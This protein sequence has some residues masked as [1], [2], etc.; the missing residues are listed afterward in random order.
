ML[1]VTIN[2]K[3]QRL[4]SLNGKRVRPPIPKS[5]PDYWSTLPT[6][7]LQELLYRLQCPVLWHLA[8]YFPQIL[9]IISS[10]NF[11]K[12]KSIELGYDSRG[13][14]DLI[15]MNGYERYVY[16]LCLPGCMY[17][18]PEIEEI[19][20]KHS[21]EVNNRMAFHGLRL[22]NDTLLYAA[23]GGHL[24]LV[25][26]FPS[27][28]QDEAMYRAA[29]GNADPRY[30]GE[31]YM[32]Q[33]LRGEYQGKDY[34]MAATFDRPEYLPSD[35]YMY[36]GYRLFHRLAQSDIGI[37]VANLYFYFALDGAC[38]V[39]YFLR[40]HDSPALRKQVRKYYGDCRDHKFLKILEPYLN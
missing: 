37:V 29:A 6:E 21:V 4:Y 36:R 25:S 8:A 3:G 26:K 31:Y 19:L 30:L 11:W 5:L 13:Y 35:T 32:G 15:G 24:D 1:T 7:I 22:T 38:Y 17:Y 28:E 33:M 2:P 34:H 14:D 40:G 10:L 27:W 23:Y 16:I 39:E 12:T 18:T 20:S 9:N